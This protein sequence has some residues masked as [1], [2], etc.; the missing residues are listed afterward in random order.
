MSR[1]TSSDNR[2]AAA[3]GKCILADY[4][5][6]HQDMCAKEFARLKDCYLVRHLPFLRLIFCLTT[7]LES[8]EE[9]MTAGS[10]FMSQDISLA[11]S[12][13]LIASQVSA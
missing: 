13:Q 10:F 8:C 2:Q 1:Y 4:Q 3:Y 9:A 7:F 11:T 5:S 6:V 12:I